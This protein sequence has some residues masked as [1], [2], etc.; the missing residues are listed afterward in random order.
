MKNSSKLGQEYLLR[1]SKYIFNK[2]KN[3]CRNPK[4]QEILKVDWIDNLEYICKN[5]LVNAFKS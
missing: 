5:N 1:H 4:I 2:I 3:I